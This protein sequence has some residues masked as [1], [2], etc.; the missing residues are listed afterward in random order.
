[1]LENIEATLNVVE[2]QLKKKTGSF[3]VGE[4]VTSFGTFAIRHPVLNQFSTGSY[5]ES[6]TI[7]KI[8]IGNR[9]FNN[10][11]SVC[12][13]RA[14]LDWD[15]LAI[16]SSK[17]TNPGVLDEDYRVTMQAMANIAESKDSEDADNF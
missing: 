11:S 15:K 17:I 7:Q 2:I 9:N 14:V 8:F 5:K 1:M 16:M 3:F 4:L 6:F 10:T 12:E 13:L